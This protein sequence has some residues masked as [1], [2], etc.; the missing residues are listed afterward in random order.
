MNG[1]VQRRGWS[2]GNGEGQHG[3]QVQLIGYG[4]S[5]GAWT[6][7]HLDYRVWR[8]GKPINPLTIPQEPSEPISKDNRAEFEFIR[9]RIMAELNGDVP[10]EERIVQLDSIVIPE[11]FVARELGTPAGKEQKSEAAEAQSGTKK[12]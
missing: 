11:G 10:A 6:G 8:N 2:K 3:T 9:D 7:P 4:G 5:T 1:Y 12:S